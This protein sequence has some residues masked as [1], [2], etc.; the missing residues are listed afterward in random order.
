MP[1]IRKSADWFLTKAHK[2]WEEH[3]LI[4]YFH[5]LFKLTKMEV[6][7]YGDVDCDSQTLYIAT[8]LRK[9]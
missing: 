8:Y 1:N 5:F 3:D 4:L 9:T 7:I 2:N 6:L